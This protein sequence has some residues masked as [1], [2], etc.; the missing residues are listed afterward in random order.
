VT[1]I[2]EDPT[3]AIDIGGTKVAIAL[4]AAGRIWERR[5]IATPRTGEGADLVDAIVRE[6]GAVMPARR[7][8]IATTGVVCEGNLTA[9]NPK[10]LPI[11]NGFP[12]SSLF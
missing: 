12:L 5:Q 10:T 3:L 7:I 4:V 8:A 1:E 9:L 2:S 6:I 11:E